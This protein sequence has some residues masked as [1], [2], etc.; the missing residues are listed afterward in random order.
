MSDDENTTSVTAE[1]H[2]LEGWLEKHGDWLGQWNR[3]WFRLCGP[4]LSYKTDPSLPDK[5]V[6]HIHGL[7][8]ENKG[9]HIRVWTETSDSWLLR[10]TDPAVHERWLEAIKAAVLQHENRVVAQ[11]KG[12][13]RSDSVGSS[14]DSAEG[15]RPAGAQR[16]RTHSRRSS[17][18]VS[19]T[20]ATGPAQ[21][22]V[23]LRAT[24]K[25]R[26]QWLRQ[27]NSRFVVVDGVDMV[28][29]EKEDGKMRGRHTIVAV[30]ATEEP[31]ELKIVASSNEDFHLRFSDDAT[32][33]H[34]LATIRQSLQTTM[35]LRW[36]PVDI[37][38]K[39]GSSVMLRTANHSAALY[40]RDGA[41]HN[42]L[43]VFGGMSSTLPA[44]AKAEE[45]AILCQDLLMVKLSGDHDCVRL[46]VKTFQEGPGAHVKPGPREGHACAIAGTRLYIHG[47]AN[48][49]TVLGDM[50]YVE[51]SAEV[52]QLAWTRV[53]NPHVQPPVVPV[54]C[55]HAMINVDDDIWMV[56]GFDGHGVATTEV[57]CYDPATNTTKPLTPLPAPRARHACAVNSALS[58]LCVGGTESRHLEDAC[59]RGY[60]MHRGDDTWHTVQWTGAELPKMVSPC[61][62]ACG[63]KGWLLVGSDGVGAVKVYF[64]QPSRS[65]KSQINVEVLSCAG[66]TPR[67]HHGLSAH[68][69]GDYL[70][71]VGDCS[72]PPIGPGVRRLLLPPSVVKNAPR[73]PSMGSMGNL[74][75]R[76]FDQHAQ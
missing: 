70:Y 22:G 39:D 76:S 9:Q 38:C 21:L 36:Q 53:T 68:R 65:D 72:L 57:L 11:P 13:L 12:I 30:D 41:D 52:Q 49:S 45:K 55:G 23:L 20:D 63:R 75:E 17:R 15:I 4:V 62:T 44:S 60:V 56:G 66:D 59:N 47:G 61:L 7:R 5:G 71:V 1:V 69:C 18:G 54:R 3:R 14:M 25:K 10:A 16:K 58:V 31:A 26:S 46:N 40:D 73:I 2:A 19:P 42:S 51:L 35:T 67:M 34:W 27:W 43:I 28:Y 6:C 74:S 37:A 48:K 24:V 32:A 50:W 64:L 33:K 8:T 29:S